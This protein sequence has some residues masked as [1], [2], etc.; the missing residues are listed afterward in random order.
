MIVATESARCGLLREHQIDNFFLR[1]SKNIDQCGRHRI[2]IIPA[3]FH[4]L[5][6]LLLKKQFGQKKTRGR[7]RIL[8]GD[9]LTAEIFEPLYRPVAFSKDQALIIGKTAFETAQDGSAGVMN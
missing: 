3:L 1:V 4:E 7:T 8:E 9:G 2:R 5:K 6:A